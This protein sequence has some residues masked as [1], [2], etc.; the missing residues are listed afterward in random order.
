MANLKLRK[1]VSAKTFNEVRLK[2]VGQ[3]FDRAEVYDI[4]T[5]QCGLKKSYYLPK[6]LVDMKLIRMDDNGNY[7]FPDNYPAT[8]PLLEQAMIACRKLEA[9]KKTS[10]YDEKKALQALLNIKNEDGTPKYEI[11]RRVPARW[12]VVTL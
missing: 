11:R 4:L 8:D 7:Y 12:E 1:K 9:P 5:K 6:V 10:D 2:M 3:K